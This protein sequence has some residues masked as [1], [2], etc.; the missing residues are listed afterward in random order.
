MH[1]VQAS[2]LL[3]LLSRKKSPCVSLYQP[4]SR[5]HPENREGPIRYRVLL[6]KIEKQL[7]GQFPPAQYR[8]ILE[9]FEA[10]KND[11]WFWRHRRRPVLQ[12]N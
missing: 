8:P 11:H 7:T 12:L 3:P 1:P 5:F 10:L 6:D 2:Q 4:T 9:K